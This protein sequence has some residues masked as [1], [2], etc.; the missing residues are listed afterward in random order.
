MHIRSVLV[1]VFMAAWL[2]WG[3]RAQAIPYQ[4]LGNSASSSSGSPSAVYHL[5][6][7]TGAAA[8]PRN[9]G[10]T[11]LT[12][13]AADPASGS[14]YGLTTFGSAP[15]N[16][17]VRIDPLTGAATTVGATGLQN[18]FEGDLAF[19]PAT[20]QLF[21]LQNIPNAPGPGDL[22][23]IDLNTGAATIVGTLPTGDYSALAF[24][25][26]GTLWLVDS[27]ASGGNNARILDTVQL[28]LDLGATV[29]L[30]F[31]PA[32]GTAYLADGGNNR[33]DMLYRLDVLSGIASP[34]G[35]IGIPEGIAGL[36]FMAVP[37][38]GVIAF[39]GFGLGA[40]LV[41]GR[42]RG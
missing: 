40:L 38:P 25:L 24:D 14:L 20:G 33:T 29:G 39:L 18:I 30:A 27:S 1:S 32:S 5:D 22:F 28:N 21:G 9:T 15:M 7:A 16:S 17:L 4:L 11:F 26:S 10:I 13:I 23:R 12:G 8:Q 6:L 3:Q 37:E 41:F 42:I 19:N 34:V 2:A 35:L 36:T 31:D